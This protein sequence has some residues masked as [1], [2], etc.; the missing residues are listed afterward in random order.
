MVEIV[1]PELEEMRNA[2]LVSIGSET[3]RSLNPDCAD[4]YVL[5]IYLLLL[6]YLN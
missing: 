5:F 3:V 4:G 6:F 2:H 1:V